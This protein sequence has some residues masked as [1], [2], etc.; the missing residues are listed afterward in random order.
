MLDYLGQYGDDVINKLFSNQNTVSLSEWV[1][2]RSKKRGYKSQPNINCSECKDI[3]LVFNNGLTICPNCGLSSDYTLID[4]YQRQP[5]P[6]KRITHF[7]D[8]LNKSQ[9]K[10]NVDFQNNL[11]EDIK[12]KLN[13]TINFTTIRNYLKK[14]KLFKH[15]ED[16]ALIEFIIT[17]KSN[18][19]LTVAEEELLCTYFNQITK[20][21]NKYKTHKRKSIIS[22]SF[23]IRELI[24]MLMSKHRQK[25]L[26]LEFFILPKADKVHEYAMVFKKIKAYYGWV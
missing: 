25:E 16:T 22:Y 11:I 23:I 14:H 18:F 17:S 1:A 13:G 2:D 21:Y 26:N 5:T 4:A 19:K 7:K 6:Y 10:H 12:T 15:Y 20:V 8:W 3:A 9:A 24:K